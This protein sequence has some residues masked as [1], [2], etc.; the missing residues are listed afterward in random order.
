[1]MLWLSPVARAVQVHESDAKQEEAQTQEE[2]RV[3]SQRQHPRLSRYFTLSVAE[4]LFIK[5]MAI[6]AKNVF[7]FIKKVICILI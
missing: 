1:M 7:F 5:C 2:E 4:L 6:D 3:G